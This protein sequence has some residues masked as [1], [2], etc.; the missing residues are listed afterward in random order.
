MVVF[1]GVL[2]FGTIF[3]A[4]EAYC[5]FEDKVVLRIT[6]ATAGYVSGFAYDFW[7]AFRK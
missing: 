7:T 5:T 2:F 6:P 3:V 1:F 4:S